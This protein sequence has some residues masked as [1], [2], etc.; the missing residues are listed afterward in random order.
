MIL[1]SPATFCITYST[2]PIV[3]EWSKIKFLQDQVEAIQIYSFYLKHCWFLLCFTLAIAASLGSWVVS[4]FAVSAWSKQ[5]QKSCK[6][7]N[8][9]NKKK[10]ITGEDI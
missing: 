10:G 6:L 3:A 7:L 4:P 9:F 2:Y 1:A 8:K 5:I